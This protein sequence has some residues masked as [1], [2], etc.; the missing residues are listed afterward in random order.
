MQ[1]PR[2]HDNHVDDWISY[3]SGALLVLLYKWVRYVREAKKTRGLTTKQA[4]M[5]W[6]F[7]NSADNVASWAVTIGIVWC[8]GSIYIWRIG[9]SGMEWMNSLPVF[10][11]LSF[12]LGAL[13]ELYAPGIARWILSKL[14]LVTAAPPEQR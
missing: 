4:T 6:F 3:I 11:G 7:E 12:L 2:V 13:M 9:I 8:G 14:P 1:H 5:E 10:C